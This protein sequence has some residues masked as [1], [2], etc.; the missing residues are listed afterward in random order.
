MKKP[1]LFFSICAS[2]LIFVN[3]SVWEGAAAAASG[4]ELPEN[5][6]YIAT[7]S[8]PPNTVVDVTNL[9]NGKTIRVI[10]ASGLESPGLLALLSRDAANAIDLPGRSLGRIS[11]SQPADPLTFS[12]PNGGSSSGDPDYDPA[13]FAA[14]NGYNPSS[15]ETGA[16]GNSRVEAGDLI[17]DLPD[18]AEVPASPVQSPS[19]VVQD[20]SIVQEQGPQ[21]AGTQ[22]Q[23][24]A[25][26]PAGS[27]APAPQ[28][29][30]QTAE[31]SFVP[32]ETRP[33]E[34]G[35]GIDTSSIIPGVASAQEAPPQAP[36][37]PSSDSSP[38]ID[39]SLII[40]SI[41]ETPKPT[42]TQVSSG[43]PGTAAAPYQPPTAVFSGPFSA[44]IIT[45]LEKG[46]YYLQIA[47]YSKEETV[48]SELSKIDNNLP[49]AIMNA[50]TQEKPVYRI[51][52]GPVNLGESGALLQ[53]FK[54]SYK[55]AF[56][57]L[58][59]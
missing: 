19:S 27:A 39:P 31:L 40:P 24:S 8:F 34:T 47:A 35:P 25:P 16:L 3:A 5:G 38:L 4:G 21:V 36:V 33:P 55:D 59:I 44:P 22:E 48:R 53:R 17:V 28:L 12:R 30:V 13:A 57:R 54:V 1:G 18:T 14:M 56:V 37:V 26:S 2:L 10:A 41:G 7:N 23:P 50:G 45:S 15:V 29:N 43:L 58:G 51:L 11:M 32:A 9:E 6:F 42:Q 52:I 20:E 46:R 49:V